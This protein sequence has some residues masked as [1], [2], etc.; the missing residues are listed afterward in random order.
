M[1]K[2]PK[3][4]IAD[5]EDSGVLKPVV[6]TAKKIT[7]ALGNNGYN[8]AVTE[9]NHSLLIIMHEDDPITTPTY[10]TIVEDL[11]HP[12]IVISFNEDEQIIRVAP[13]KN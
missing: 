13:F 5:F 10:N 8:F 12:G 1:E 6:E 4:T 7:Y 2:I 9:Y 3:P 11:T